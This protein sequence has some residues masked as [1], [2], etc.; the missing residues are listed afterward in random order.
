M[1]F[2]HPKKN[3][4]DN[5]ELLAELARTKVALDT[6]YSNFEN[7]VDP[8]LIDCS[9]YELNAIQQRYKYLLKQ[10][11]TDGTPAAISE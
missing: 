2:F 3:D 6:A 10:L 11:K 1:L 8:D 4:Q 7:V 5:S 9:I